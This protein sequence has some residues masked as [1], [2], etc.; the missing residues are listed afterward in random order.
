MATSAVPAVK[1]ALFAALQSAYPTGVQVCY[2]RPSAGAW[3]AEDVVALLDVDATQDAPLLGARAR[4][5]SFR[6][7]V[8]VSSA[9]G[10]DDQQATTE[11]AYAL[12]ATLEAALR[13]DPTVAGTCRTA[14]V[15]GHLLREDEWVS[16]DG[17]FLGR[18]AEIAAA[19]AVKARI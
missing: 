11:A 4:E 8:L 12:L 6:L 5:E 2:G 15:V 19:V 17:V 16:P 18:V 3:L 1:A 13:A 10:G 9:R 14:E 7:T